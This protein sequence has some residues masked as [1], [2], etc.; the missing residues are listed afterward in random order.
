MEQTVLPGSRLSLETGPG[1]GSR[2]QPPV[3]PNR[4]IR[5][6]EENTYDFVSKDSWP[7]SSPDLNPMD[8]FVWGYLEAHT[9]RRAHTTKASL[10]NSIKENCSSLDRA[11]VAKACASFRGHVEAVIEAGGGFLSRG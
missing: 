6:L 1:S 9:N 4:S 2:T 7:P 11:M 8:Y 3:R 5:W 10:I